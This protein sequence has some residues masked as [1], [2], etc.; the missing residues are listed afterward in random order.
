M[1]LH[2]KLCHTVGG[3]FNLPH[4][5]THAIMLPHAVAYNAL[6]VPDA[7]ARLARALNVVDPVNAL[8]DL[9]RSVGAPAALRDLGMPEAGLEQAVD[10]V[11]RNPYWNPRPLDRSVLAELLR[12]AWAG[13]RPRT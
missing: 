8:F 7:I 5:E 2:H 3:S 13:E 12:R 11:I 9:A 4:A 1:A 6:A 10:Q